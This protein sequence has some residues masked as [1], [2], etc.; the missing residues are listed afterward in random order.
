VFIRSTDIG[1]KDMKY[2]PL[3]NVGLRFNIDYQ[4]A[5]GPSNYFNECKGRDEH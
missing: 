2:R 5:I 1:E 3:V 4:I